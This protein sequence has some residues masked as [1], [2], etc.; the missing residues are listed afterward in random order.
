MARKRGNNDGSIRQRKDGLWE[1]RIT[2]GVNSNG[3]QNRKSVYGS[4]QAEVQKKLRDILQK[5]EEGDYSEP[6]RMTVGAWLDNWCENYGAPHWREKTLEVHRDNIRLHLKP[7]LGKIQLRKLRADHIQ[8]YI[9]TEQ[10]AGTASATIRK[11][12][13]PLQGALKQATANRL[14]PYN[15]A[16]HIN[17][18]QNHSKEIV[19]LTVEEQKKL[20][21]VLPDNT[22]GRAIRFVLFTGLRASELCGLRWCDVEADSF[23]IRQGAQYIRQADVKP[24]EAKQKLSIAPPKTK[25]GKRTIPL[26][27]AAKAI[28]EAQRQA[29]RQQRLK[30]GAAWQSG[31]P[32]EGNT[33]VFATELGTI[34]ERHNL[35]R[36]LKTYLRAAGLQDRGLHALR[37]TFATNWVHSGADLRTLSEILGHTKVAFTMQQYVHSDMGAKLAG[38]KAVENF[39]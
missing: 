36:A 4:S 2:I 7:A 8:A 38:L 24:G 31:I 22:P 20:L 29:Q 33:P 23:T 35:A 5:V 26:T 32:G 34:Y 28:L 16:E 1:G 14:I 19:F 21:A 18:P 37:H 25:A 15:P 6:S 9:N 17:L 30:I 10:K 39:V 13:E 11:R 12:M 27:E 3:T